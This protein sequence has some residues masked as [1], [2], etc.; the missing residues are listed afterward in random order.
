MSLVKKGRFPANFVQLAALKMLRRHLLQAFV[1]NLQLIPQTE[2]KKTGSVAYLASFISICW[3]ISW[4]SWSLLAGK[5]FL[6]SSSCLL[7]LFRSLTASSS[8]LSLRGRVPAVVQKA[9]E[10]N[11]RLLV[12]H[13]PTRSVAKVTSQILNSVRNL[14]TNAF[15]QVPAVLYSSNT[16]V[17]RVTLTQQP[18]F[19][20]LTYLLTY[21]LTNYLTKLN[22][23]ASM[24]DEMIL[25]S[26]QNIINMLE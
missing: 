24:E 12:Y 1:T 5:M 11:T 26:L 23:V 15:V 8:F 7:G 4:R 21:L 19:H 9:I 25:C 14:L 17:H 20:L 3:R 16:K 6:S 2:T 13:H 18:V 10:K 22:I